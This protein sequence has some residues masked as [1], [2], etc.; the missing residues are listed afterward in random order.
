M[1]INTVLENVKNLIAPEVKV[2]QSLSL[3][4]T[5]YP[6]LSGLLRD[7]ADAFDLKPLRSDES[8]YR[9]KYPGTSI[10]AMDQVKVLWGGK[11]DE[12]PYHRLQALL[13]IK[14]ADVE[15]IELKLYEN[16]IGTRAE[17]E[18]YQEVLRQRM[19]KLIAFLEAGMTATT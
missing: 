3:S 15:K 12:A 16:L 13:D 17:Q 2:E 6:K 7:L 19:E 8:T 11:P 9:F 10:V 4:E 5:Q 18:V 1:T 14:Q